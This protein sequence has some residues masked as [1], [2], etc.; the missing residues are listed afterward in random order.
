VT[1]EPHDV[2]Y[3]SV[4]H[5]P[6]TEQQLRAAETRY[7]TAARAPNTLRGYRADWVEVTNS[8]SSPAPP[9]HDAARSRS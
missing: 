4:A 3:L 1:G 9:T 6:A 2:V 7:I 5:P 8:S